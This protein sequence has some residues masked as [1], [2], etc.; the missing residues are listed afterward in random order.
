MELNLR[1]VGLAAEN[2]SLTSLRTF[3]IIVSAYHIGLGDIRKCFH[4]LDAPV[5]GVNAVKR[6][7][8]FVRVFLV[9]SIITP[10]LRLTVS[11][12]P[13]QDLVHLLLLVDQLRRAVD[14]VLLSG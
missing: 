4:W 8:V 14:L 11:Y 1:T 2:L 6:D 10:L 5:G 7:N 13:D 12:S 9:G 3:L